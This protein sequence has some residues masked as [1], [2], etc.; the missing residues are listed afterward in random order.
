MCAV[1]AE[2]LREEASLDGLKL[3]IHKILSGLGRERAHVSASRTRLA[4]RPMSVLSR[5][6]PDCRCVPLW[7]HS[8][9]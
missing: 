4:H 3:V 9:S 8:V 6:S 2:S 7:T 1:V 5:L